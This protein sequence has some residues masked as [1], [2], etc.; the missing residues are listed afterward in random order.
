VAS[1]A[2]VTVLAGCG[3]SPKREQPPPVALLT[4]VRATASDAGDRVVFAFRSPPERVSARYVG[5][6]DLV[7]DGSGARVAVA[8]S[9]F[10]V[11]RFE[12]ASGFDLSQPPGE[13]TYHG[14]RRFTPEGTRVVREVV[15]LGDFEAVL[16]WAIGLSERRSYTIE[17]HGDRV[18]LQLR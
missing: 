13:L 8:G 3:G 11:V 2:L 7:E 17:R 5:A 15:R 14:P 16:T 4:D 6:S 9:A 1:T 18:I 10:L 12:P